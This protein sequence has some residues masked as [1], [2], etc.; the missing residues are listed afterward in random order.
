MLYKLGRDWDS[1]WTLFGIGTVHEAQY[2]YL[3][4]I[5]AYIL[6]H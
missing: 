1:D 4:K 5:R 6:I 2:K 3:L